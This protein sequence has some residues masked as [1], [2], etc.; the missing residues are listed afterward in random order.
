MNR[1][2]K[3]TCAALAAAFPG[4]A[5]YAQQTELLQPIVV[6]S[7]IADFDPTGRINTLSSLNILGDKHIVDTPFSIRNY[8]AKQFKETMSTTVGEVLKVDPGIRSNTNEGHINE[9][10]SIRGFDSKWEDTNLNGSYGMA[11]TGRVPT[12]ILDSVTVL[13]GPNALVAGMPPNGGIGGTVMI[14]TKRANTDLNE[15]SAEYDLNGYWSPTIDVARR[16]G[17]EKQFGARASVNYGEGQHVVR[18]LH[19]KD[20]NA[21]VALDYTTDRTKINLDAYYVRTHRKDGSPAMIGFPKLG[22]VLDSP[23][24]KNNYFKHLWAKQNG[25]YIGL[26]LEQKLLDKLTFEGGFGFN[27]QEYRGHVFGTRMIVQDKAGNATSQYYGI[28]SRTLNQTAYLSL[29]GIFHTGALEHNVTARGDFLNIREKKHE[30]RGA[31]PVDFKTNLYHPSHGGHMPF[32]D[33]H[34]I[35]QNDSDY[36]SAS[37]VDQISVYDDALQFIIGARYQDMD[38][39]DHSNDTKYDDH[40]ISPTFAVVLKPFEQNWSFYGSYVE[41]LIRG[42]TVNALQDANY[43]QTFAP[44]K[45][46]QYEIGTKYQSDSWLH[47]LAFYQIERPTTVTDMTYRDKA[48]KKITQRTTDDGKSK[49]KGVEY[50][51]SGIM[52]DDTLTVLG[53]VAYLEAE[54]KR[55]Q[56]GKMSLEGKTIEGQPEWTAGLSLDYKIPYVPGL[57]INGR[58]TFVNHQ[59]IDN[60]NEMRIPSYAIFDVGASYTTKVSGVETTFRAGVENVG[61]R[62]YWEGVFNSGYA[63]IGEGRTAKLGVTFNF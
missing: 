32:D 2:L 27:E 5:A 7:E 9:N 39:R 30:G 59:Y 12:S 36:Y 51:F 37:L 26:S 3:Y 52:F 33:P 18:G 60:A 11:P 14:H 16:F 15:I 41:A 31:K 1:K 21:V 20:V 22:E 24:P 25:K 63:L 43:G 49:S 47:T 61:N 29:N 45:A 46:K 56:A 53:N 35:N 57:S 4:A 50:S 54:Y 6:T 42:A 17:D 58:A 8:S 19:D 44:Y 28:G 40:K 38:I 13:K 55:G 34:M 62:R 10:F 48:N 23:D